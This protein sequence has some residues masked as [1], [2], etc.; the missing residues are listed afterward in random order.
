MGTLK[1]G[2]SYT[3]DGQ[4]VIVDPARADELGL[5][6]AAA[7]MREG[8]LGQRAVTRSGSHRIEV[9]GVPGS[10]VDVAS[11]VAYIRGEYGTES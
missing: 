1:D 4:E 7:W 9:G 10:V 8:L 3:L 2:G 6:E 5:H 11:A